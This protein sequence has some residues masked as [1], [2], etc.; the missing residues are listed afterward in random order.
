M[1]RT[2][3]FFRERRE[4]FIGY[5]R[6]RVDSASAA[7]AEDIVQDVFLGLFDR[8]DPT[9]PIQDLAA[10]VYQSLRNRIVDLFRK[11]R[12]ALPLKEDVPAATGDPSLDWEKREALEEV[13]AALE[14]LSPDEKAVIL[15]TELEGRSFKE[16]SAEW[17][18]PMGTLLARKSRGIEKIRKR[19]TARRAVEQ[20][21]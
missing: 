11:R 13:F 14:A 12:D 5:V 19:L 17:D 18:I 7:D 6:R 16:L 10:F 8:A 21:E 4:A 15:E 2:T 9:I 1:T 3:D 20:G